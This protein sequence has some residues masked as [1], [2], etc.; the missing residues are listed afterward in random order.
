MI[1][2]IL[3]I[4]T[5]NIIA[6]KTNK[7]L[8]YKQIAHV[9]VFTIALQ[10][11]FDV[12]VDLK[13]LG[14]WYFTPDIDWAA[15]LPHTFLIPPVN[16][17]FINL[18]PFHRSLWIKTRYILYWTIVILG[19]ELIALLPEPWGYFNYGWWNLGYSAV[20]DVILLNILIAY[21]KKFIA[22]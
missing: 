6:F 9:W 4:L 1:G 12:Y 8:N 7:I 18:Y 16:M 3:A 15:F 13:Y 19:Y 5:F 10:L 17:V 2:L 22:D 21:Y 11:S 14:Y 20:L